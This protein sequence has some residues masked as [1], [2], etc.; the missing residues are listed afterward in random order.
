MESWAITIRK[1]MKVSVTVTEAD[2][3]PILKKMGAKLKHHVFEQDKAK[4]HK[5]LH[6]IV[7]LPRNY[8]RKNIQLK[9]FHTYFERIYNLNG[10]VK[11]MEKDLDLR[12]GISFLL[13]VQDV[14]SES[15]RSCP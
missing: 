12:Q 13:W 6:G 7:E 14:T 4:D 5:H 3:D 10:W 15:K 11:Y 9:G 1:Q 8:F 2:F